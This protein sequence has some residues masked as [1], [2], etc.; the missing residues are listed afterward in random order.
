M[1]S[2]KKLQR[3]VW[4]DLGCGEKKFVLKDSYKAFA[5]PTKEA[6]FISF[7]ERKRKQLQ[8]VKNQIYDLEFLQ[9]VIKKHELYKEHYSR[10]PEKSPH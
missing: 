6:A 8:I 9:Q 1:Q 7:Q 4:L 5:R 3:G 10:F 2:S